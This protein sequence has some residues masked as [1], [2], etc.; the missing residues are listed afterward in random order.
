MRDFLSRPIKLT[1]TIQHYEWGNINDDAFIPKLLGIEPEKDLP[2]AELWIGAHPKAP[3]KVSV[4]G[5]QETLDKLINDYPVEILGEE[6]ALKFKNKLPFLLKVLSARKALSIQT[7][8]NKSQAVDLHAKD[9]CNYP[10]DNHKPEIA[11]ALDEL[12]AI[13]G[14]KSRRAS[15]EVFD[16]YPE[17][18]KYFERN[19]F[20]IEPDAL[21]DADF[22]RS[23][24]KFINAQD[25]NPE[26]E[27]LIQS[28]SES[29]RLKKDKNSFE[30][31]WLNTLEEYGIESG[32]L[33]FFFFNFLQLKRNEGF[34]TYAGIPHA[35]L[36]G[37]IV[38]CM[39]N[40]DNVVRAGLTPKF[41]DVATLE[42]IINYDADKP[43]V[44]TPVGVKRD[45]PSDVQE[46]VLTGLK[47]VKGE[48]ITNLINN[49]V[50]IALVANGEV[51]VNID[52]NEQT[53][54]CKGDS[55]LVAACNKDYTITALANSEL[56][57]C[58]VP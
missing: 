27:A 39:A 6:V 56:Y 40:S 19:S 17:I 2:Y 1:N 52:E 13:V 54:F 33:A 8:P 32:M 25:D 48:N 20:P 30:K 46:F 53:R 16:L 35:Y 55:F 5:K 57:I 43:V 41:K 12:D 42:K 51:D 38:E 58:S 45:Y 31:V 50:V 9:P 14:I 7:H 34:F 18:R 26:L 29:I 44:L 11:I 10:D 21:S 36:K 24:I 28:L 49:R 15:K 22:N 4:N 47:V 37:N 23:L 3:S